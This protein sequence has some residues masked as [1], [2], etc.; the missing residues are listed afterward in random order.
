MSEAHRKAFRKYVPYYLKNYVFFPL[1]AGPVLLEGARSATGWPRRM[2]DVYSAATIYCGH[3]GDDVAAYPEGTRAH[4]RG[5]VVRDA[6]RGHQQLRGQPAV[7][8]LCGGA[9]PADRAPPLSQAAAQPAARDRPEVRAVCDKYG[10]K[11]KTASW[12]KTLKKALKRI[13]QLSRP[14]EI[15]REMV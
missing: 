1:L 6:G 4:G 14:G 5:A 3:V 11:Y 2:R 8:I 12:G 7:S 10:V 13:S 15:A 9:R